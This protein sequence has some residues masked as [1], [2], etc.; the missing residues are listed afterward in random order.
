MK[1]PDMFRDSYQTFDK[2]TGERISYLD[3]LQY[4]LTSQQEPEEPD[5]NENQ[6]I[7]EL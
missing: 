6:L 2:K 1:S 5:F 7:L 3:Q 4:E